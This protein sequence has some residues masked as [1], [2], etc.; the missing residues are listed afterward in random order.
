MGFQIMRSG[1]PKALDGELHTKQFDRIVNSMDVL[2]LSSIWWLPT[3]RTTDNTISRDGRSAGV[4]SFGVPAYSRSKPPQSSTEE[5]S[6]SPRSL[7]C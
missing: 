3:S 1:A 4:V 7:L 2:I 6:H 5:D